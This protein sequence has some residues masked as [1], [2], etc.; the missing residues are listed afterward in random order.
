MWSLEMK[1]GK[2]NWIEFRERERFFLS[3]FL[4]FL[5]FFC[6]LS[7]K[8]LPSTH[9]HT[10]TFFIIHRYTLIHTHIYRRVTLVHINTTVTASY[11]K[12]FFGLSKLF[13]YSFLQLSILFLFSIRIKYTLLHSNIFHFTSKT[14]FSLFC[15][16]FLLFAL[17]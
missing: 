12:T 4:S 10:H 2:M 16:C 8:N 5:N 15:C 9:T 14:F 13:K 6:V 17:I 11:W 3:F 7:P 1:W